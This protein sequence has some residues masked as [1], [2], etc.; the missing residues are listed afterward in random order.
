[1][2]SL[3]VWIAWLAT[4]PAYVGQID[5]RVELWTLSGDKI[6]KALIDVEVRREAEHYELLFT[7]DDEL[8]AVVH[9]QTESETDAD[10][11]VPFMGTTF[12][13]P[14]AQVIGTEE[15]RR[16]SKS[17]RSLYEEDTRDWKATLR[18]YRSKTRDAKNAWM[19][20]VERGETYD[21]WTV[22]RFPLRVD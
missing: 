19:V 11:V 14:K 3:L 17:G 10:V 2:S 22:V 21:D 7:R 18:A 16:F 15:Q 12:L 4:S 1:M 8:V 13:R 6:P 5:V 9:G 20:F